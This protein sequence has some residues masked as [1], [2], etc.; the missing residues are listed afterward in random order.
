MTSS[1]SSRS[2]SSCVSPHSR[3]TSWECS[4]SAGA[5]R[6][7]LPGVCEAIGE[8][9]LE[10]NPRFD[11][12]AKRF[13]N[14]QDLIAHLDDVFARKPAREWVQRFQ[15]RSLM[16][17]PV[18][19]YEDLVSDPQVIANG[20]IQEVERPGHEPVRMVGVPVR[21]SRTPGH[22]RRLAAGLGEHPPGGF[23]G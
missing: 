10:G 6:R 20:Y 9:E 11:T 4:P 3:S 5:S 14:G 1:R 19:D 21:F 16:V 18:Q 2:I 7:I 17:A 8:P 22:T 12:A 23:S 13:E 15:E